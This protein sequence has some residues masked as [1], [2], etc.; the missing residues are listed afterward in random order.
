[1]NRLKRAGIDSLALP[2]SERLFRR[3]IIVTAKVTDGI[4][5]AADSAASFF[6]PRAAAPIKI[7]NHANKIVNL[8]KG[9][10]IG[11]MIYGSRSIGASS[12]ETLSKDLRARL[13]DRNNP[14]YGLDP[15]NY[16]VQEVAGKAR[17]FLYEESYLTAYNGP[18]PNFLMG[19]RVCGYSAKASLSEPLSKNEWVA[20]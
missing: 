12:V 19:Y 4:V 17:K 8:V 14:D 16:T 10:P 2:V 13:S 1:M 11:A 15:D 3:T 18:P 5:L 7:Y 20:A 9:M 6:L